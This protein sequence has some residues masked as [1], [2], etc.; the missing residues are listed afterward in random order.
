MVR[1][2]I[3]YEVGYFNEELKIH[4][5][6]DMWN[7]ISEKYKLGYIEKPLFI[8]RWEINQDHLLKPAARKEF[9]SEGRKYMKL[10]EE[11]RKG[12]ELTEREKAGI[13]DSYRQIE[14]LEQLIKELYDGKLTEEEFEIRRLKLQ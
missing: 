2:S 8:F 4:E 13:E 11:R 12:R 1:K 10:Y 9:M 6:T 3:F 14:R 5:D 7:R